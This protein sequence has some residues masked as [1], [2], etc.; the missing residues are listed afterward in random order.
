M[1]KD[2]FFVLYAGPVAD[3][4]DRKVYESALDDFLGLLYGAKIKPKQAFIGRGRVEA[5]EEAAAYAAASRPRAPESGGG[6]RSRPAS[7]GRP[8]PDDSD[9]IRSR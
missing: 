5:E 9:G 2:E 8:S 3:A 7:G 4:L 1:P 6:R